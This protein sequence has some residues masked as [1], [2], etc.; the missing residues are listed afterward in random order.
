NLRIN[1]KKRITFIFRKNIIKILR[2]Y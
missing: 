1:Y 2:S